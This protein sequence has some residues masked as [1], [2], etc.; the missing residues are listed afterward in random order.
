MVEATFRQQYGMKP[1]EVFDLTWR[2]FRTLFDH[3]FTRD[4]EA[5]PPEETYDWNAALDKAVGRE[6]ASSRVKMSVEEFMK[7][8]RR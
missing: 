7:G 5:S 1:H 6:P 3:V 4:E 2:E 8:Q